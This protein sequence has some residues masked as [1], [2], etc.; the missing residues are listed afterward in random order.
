M[1]AGIKVVR[2]ITGESL[3]CE[4]F[5]KGDTVHVKEPARQLVKH[6]TDGVN[7]TTELTWS[8][9]APDAHE[10]TFEF[11]LM[12]VITMYQPKYELA[13]SYIEFLNTV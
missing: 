6:V 4:A 12:H 8:L 2:L 7:S 3:V 13:E 1:K 5:Q 9:Y 11:N 10:L